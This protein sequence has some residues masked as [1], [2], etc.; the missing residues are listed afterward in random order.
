MALTNKDKNFLIKSMA[1]SKKILK[2]FGK[3]IP[4]NEVA[5]LESI[6]PA[7]KN[8]SLTQEQIK[9]LI[10]NMESVYLTT[11]VKYVKELISNLESMLETEEKPVEK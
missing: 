4:E 6:E 1:Q 3:G 9:F 2:L 10:K 5:F 7:I 11:K 8:D